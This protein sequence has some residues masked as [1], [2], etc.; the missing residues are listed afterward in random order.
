MDGVGNVV[1]RS[2]GLPGGVSVTKR[3]S[4][5]VWSYP[6]LH[7][8]VAAVADQNGAKQ[9]ATFTYD[10]YGNSLNGQI[11]DNKDGALDAGWI[12]AR[13][14][15][16][17]T[18]LAPIIEMGARQYDPRL[19]R[20]LET[21]P[22]EGGSCNDYDYVC[23]DPIGARDLDGTRRWRNRAA[24]LW[25]APRAFH[26][27]R[28]SVGK[29]RKGDW[30]VVAWIGRPLHAGSGAQLLIPLR[31][32]NQPESPKWGWEHIQTKHPDVTIDNIQAVVYGGK[33]IDRNGTSVLLDLTFTQGDWWRGT[34]WL[35]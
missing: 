11:P 19:G 26:R 30:S 2:F 8:D 25:A 33:E 4:S 18:G 29:Y 20:F 12:G 3:T 24:N 21:D 22:I 28:P 27:A 35:L 10:P 7:G 15:A 9:G 34:L 16:H 23:A 13:S 6:N 32:G 5:Q 14:T 31:V 17:E 1:E